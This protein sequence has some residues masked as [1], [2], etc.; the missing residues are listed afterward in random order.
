MIL[1]KEENLVE[2]KTLNEQTALHLAAESGCETTV[3]LLAEKRETM[4]ETTDKHGN[5]PLFVA[6]RY[7]RDSCVKT[8]IEKGAK[9]D[10]R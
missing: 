2:D 5:T 1:S 4:I 7:G 6:A 9:T 10:K 8:L 3:K